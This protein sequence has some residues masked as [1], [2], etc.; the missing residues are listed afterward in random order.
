MTS[1]WCQPFTQVCLHLRLMAPGQNELRMLEHFEFSELKVE[2]VVTVEG[3]PNMR[4]HRCTLLIMRITGFPR[5]RPCHPSPSF[6]VQ[7]GGWR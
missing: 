1:L 2:H 5:K 4:E 3:A 7:L 6:P